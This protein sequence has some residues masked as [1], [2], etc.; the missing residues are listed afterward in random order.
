LLDQALKLLA[1][2]P[3]PTQLGMVYLMADRPDLAANRAGSRPA[4]A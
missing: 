2:C 4:A 3:P 1:T